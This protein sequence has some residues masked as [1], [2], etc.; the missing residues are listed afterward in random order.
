MD[1]DFIG[2]PCT[3][4]SWE[5]LC[6][7]VVDENWQSIRD[8]TD[9]AHLSDYLEPSTGDTLLIYLLKQNLWSEHVQHQLQFI[10]SNISNIAG[11]TALDFVSPELYPSFVE[12]NMCIDRKHASKFP[13]GLHALFLAIKC[14]TPTSQIFASFPLSVFGPDGN[15]EIAGGWTTLGCAARYGKG[16][17]IQT[18]AN[19]FPNASPF[20]ALFQAIRA[21]NKSA[22]KSLAT[23]YSNDVLIEDFDN[24]SP[25]SF[26][27]SQNDTHGIISLL[28]QCFPSLDCNAQDDAGDTALGTAASIQSVLNITQLHQSFPAI[29]PNI[30]S[31]D[32]YTPLIWAA[33]YGASD[34]IRTLYQCFPQIDVRLTDHAG[35]SA[36]HW[37]AFANS[38]DSIIALHE[39]FTLD[40]NQR[41]EDGVTP[42][43]VA[44]MMNSSSAIQAMR[45][46]DVDPNFFLD[47]DNHA[48]DPNLVPKEQKN[49]CPPLIWA[50]MKRNCD[51]IQALSEF[52]AINPNIQ[53]HGNFTPLIW[54]IRL[55]STECVEMLL[56]CF[57][58]LD[59]N[60]RDF[61]GQTALHWAVQCD[62]GFITILSRHFGSSL[63]CNAQNNRGETA[64]ISAARLESRSKLVIWELHEAFPNIDPH[65]VDFTNI[66]ATTAATPEARVV[67]RTIFRFDQASDK[68]GQPQGI[69]KFNE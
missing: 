11:Q 39:C 53:S 5:T 18:F 15:A 69:A 40:F 4:E 26:A 62:S 31:Y 10:D 43:M 61:Q 55:T 29:D 27:C 66:S 33:Q 67:I 41:T 46:L 42:L 14:E 64:L 2:Y 44:A 9:S 56:R 30:Q 36:L 34:C 63:D 58:N 12:I 13:R 48:Q 19:H 24:T 28:S 47:L 32:G 21:N 8:R 60:I 3:K 23:Y 7:L 51:C 17:F 37:A 35:H 68:H 20:G 59:P 54:A 52:S 1:S 22:I 16:D 50:T 65:I 6:E 25:L 38:Y 49:N 57:P 45:V